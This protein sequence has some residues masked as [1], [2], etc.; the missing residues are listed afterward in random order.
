LEVHDLAIAKLV[1][2][3]PKD[4]DFLRHS[5]QAGYITAETLK[6]RLENTGLDAEIGKVARERLARLLGAAQIE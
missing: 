6:S 2:G 3:R 4:L 1:A 5:I